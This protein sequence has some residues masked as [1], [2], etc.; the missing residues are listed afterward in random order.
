MQTFYMTNIVPQLDRLNQDMWGKLEGKVRSNN[1]SD[2]LFVVTGVFYGSNSATTADGEN[3][4]V[5]VPTHF[6]KLL[7][8]TKSG[9]TGKNIKDCKE[10]ELKSIGFWVE[11]KSYGDIQ[12]PKEICTTV[13]DIEKKT[14]FKFFPNVPDAVK[15]QNDPN[16][17]GI[18]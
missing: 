11:H 15:N 7:L 1:C 6:Y 13:A 9:K 14:G 17:W 18:R 4:K 8:R 12:P 10:N 16:S 3:V 2:T 5:P